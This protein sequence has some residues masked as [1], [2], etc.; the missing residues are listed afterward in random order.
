M[1][2]GDAHLDSPYCQRKQLKADLEQAR[3]C[4]AIVIDVGDLFD[5]MQGRSDGRANK[6][7]LLTT[8]LDPA[9]PITYQKSYFDVTIDDAVDFLQ[10]FAPNLSIFAVGNHEASVRDKIETNPTMRLVKE[11]NY[12]GANT[13]CGGYQGWAQFKFRVPGGRK[14]FTKTAFYFHGAGGGGQVTKGMPNMI[15]K[16]SV[17]DTPDILASGHIHEMWSHIHTIWA[18]SSSGVPLHK[19]VLMLLTGTYK[20]EAGDGAENWHNETNKPPKPIGSYKVRCY[21]DTKEK[22]IKMEPRLTF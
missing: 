13:F 15:R 4:N 11:L 10:P 16:L 21:W 20:N 17:I 12:R 18:L 19:D 6:K 5:L 22:K 9:D 8:Y 3:D 2:M 1:W 7:E 14:H